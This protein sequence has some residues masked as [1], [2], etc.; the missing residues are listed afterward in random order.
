MHCTGGATKNTGA[1]A[2]VQRAKGERASAPKRKRAYARVCA[3]S[4]VALAIQYTKTRA[5]TIQNH[6]K[7]AVVYG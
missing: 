4:N 2:V 6:D 5:T 1:H 3:A 7:S